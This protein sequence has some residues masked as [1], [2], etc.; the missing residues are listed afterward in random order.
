[1]GYMNKCDGD[2]R[3]CCTVKGQDKFNWN[4]FSANAIAVKGTVRSLWEAD[5][6][7]SFEPLK[8]PGYRCS[9][10]IQWIGDRTGNK[11]ELDDGREITNE[12]DLKKNWNKEGQTTFDCS[13]YPMEGGRVGR[14][15]RDY[16]RE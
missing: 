1:M 7:V 3:R 16:Q 15:E 14:R 6:R 9:P 2:W 12:N 10:F 4:T 11:I 8:D 5:V 13:K